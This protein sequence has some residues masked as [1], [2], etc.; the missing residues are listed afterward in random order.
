M[1]SPVQTTRISAPDPEEAK[2]LRKR[3]EDLFTPLDR[4]RRSLSRG[5]RGKS[6]GPNDADPENQA[7]TRARAAARRVY[8]VRPSRSKRQAAA[9]ILSTGAM[10]LTAFTSPDMAR[11]GTDTTATDMLS[12]ERL[13][14]GELRASE[15]L[16]QALL[17]EDGVRHTVYR[18][19]AGYPTVGIGHLVQPKDG[20]QVGDRISNAQAL[21]FLAA[22]LRAAEEEARALLGDLEVHQHE[23][24]ALVDLI[25]NV[26]PGKV[27]P[28]ESPR[29]NDAIARGDHDA[30]AAEL[31][32]TSAAGR[33]LRGLDFRSE[34][35]TQMFL[36]ASYHDPRT[37]TVG[38]A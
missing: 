33:K 36:N 38:T 4:P 9:L 25:Y 5:Q 19:A 31:T 34:R 37:A 35:R 26:G 20:L 18:D 10:G 23:F 11:S 3:V 16:K 27:G 12:G 22:D 30:I 21:A 13:S 28:A 17:D 2:R 6:G 1:T 24:D 29:L 15:A 8:H 32:Y 7:L 14:P